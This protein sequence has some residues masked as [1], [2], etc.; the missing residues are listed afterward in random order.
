VT[1]AEN[2]NGKEVSNDATGFGKLPETNTKICSDSA[3]LKDNKGVY[4]YYG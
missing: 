2:D 3:P 4:R 1:N